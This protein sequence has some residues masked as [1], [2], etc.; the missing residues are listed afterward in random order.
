MSLCINPQCLSPAN[1]DRMSFCQ[2]CGSELLL[3]H[4]YQ[5]TKLMSNK[6][7]FGNTYEIV[8]QQEPKVLKVL[9]SDNPKAIELFEREY[10]VLND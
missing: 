7:G 4:K 2:S 8:E 1:S 9:K 10:R 5:V 3:A 6:G